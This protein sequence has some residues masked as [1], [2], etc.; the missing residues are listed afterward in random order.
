METKKS[1]AKINSSPSILDELGRQK[2]LLQGDF[3]YILLDVK[4]FNPLYS[5]TQCEFSCTKK[6]ILFLGMGANTDNILTCC[7]KKKQI[8]YLEHEEFAKQINVQVPANFIK[9]TP[10]ELLSLCDDEFFAETDILFYKQNLQLFPGFWNNIL[11]ELRNKALLPTFSQPAGKQKYIFLSGGKNDLLHRELCQAIHDIGSTPVEIGQKNLQEILELLDA[12]PPLLYLAVNAQSLD[13][14]GIIYQYLKQKNIPLALWFVDNVWN[15]LSGFSQ[16][17]WKECHLY[18]TDFSFAKELQKEGAK[19]IF[20]L[21]LASHNLSASYQTIPEIPLFFVGNSSF[22]NKKSYFSGCKLE[23]DFEQNLYR[24]IKK[25]LFAQKEIPDFHSIYQELLPNQPLWQNKQGRT[26]GY[27]AAKADLYLR[28]LWLEGLSPLIHI[29][30]DNAWQDILSTAHTFYKPVDY[31]NNLPTYYKNSLFTLNLTSLL[32]PANLSQRHFDV[33][34][35]QGFLLSSPSSGMKIFPQ[36]MQSIITV[37]NPQ[38]CL[39]R[40]EL[41]LTKPALKTEIQATMQNEIAQKNCYTHRLQYILEH[42]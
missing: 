18:L 23:H 37:N 19:N 33:W 10:N 38:D 12:N 13:G 35:H 11:I 34:K 3:S 1:L 8:F 5:R 20:P 6:Q 9:I 26:I 29:M 40:L 21:P 27:A 17:W 41:L 28:K 22:A 2:T 16:K 42:C 39:N 31:Y 24:T 4:N 30:G 36:D 14:N 32:M 7:E 25:N 15:I